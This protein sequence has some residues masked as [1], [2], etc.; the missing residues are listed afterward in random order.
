[1]T[2]TPRAPGDARGCKAH[3]AGRELFTQQTLV[4]VEHPTKPFEF[5]FEQPIKSKIKRFIK[6]LK[7]NK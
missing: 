3:L 5:R 4:L 7:I 1:M 2:L 6:F